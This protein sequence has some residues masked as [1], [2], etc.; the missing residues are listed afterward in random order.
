MGLKPAHHPHHAVEYALEWTV[1]ALARLAGVGVG[2]DLIMP[3]LA[4]QSVPS[5]CDTGRASTSRAPPCG[6]RIA[7]ISARPCPRSDRQWQSLRSRRGRRPARCPGSPQGCRP[8]EDLSR[9][10]PGIRRIGS[11][12]RG[13]PDRMRNNSDLLP[14]VR[15]RYLAAK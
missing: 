12:G 8:R 13:K 5:A 9:N 2:N 10:Y 7:R 6:R 14:R 11:H 15:Q 1:K 3:I 4:D